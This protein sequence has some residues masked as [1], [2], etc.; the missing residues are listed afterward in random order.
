MATSQVEIKQ[1][2]AKTIKIDMVNYPTL[3]TEV[4]WVAAFVNPSTNERYLSDASTTQGTFVTFH[5]P[6]GLVDNPES[7]DYGKFDE[8]K[9]NG[10][11]YMDVGVYNF[12]LYT[13]DHSDMGVLYER[14]RVTASS[15]MAN[16]AP[17]KKTETT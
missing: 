5:W 9:P 17:T 13:S 10:T 16:N 11:A 3:P 8:S 7:E 6:S 12:E 14:F 15:L 1:G 4:T 2:I